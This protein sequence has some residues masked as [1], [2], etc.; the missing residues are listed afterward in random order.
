MLAV[1][2]SACL[3][4]LRRVEMAAGNSRYG[5]PN[6]RR[7]DAANSP[8]STRR[9]T[10]DLRSGGRLTATSEADVR[11]P[12]RAAYRARGLRDGITATSWPGSSMPV[13]NLKCAERLEWTRTFPGG[14]GVLE[15]EL[16]SSSRA[17]A[18]SVAISRP[19]RAVDVGGGPYV[20]GTRKHTAAEHRSQ[21]R[22]HLPILTA[23][24][25]DV[26]LYRS[27]TW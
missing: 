9:Q 15:V 13:G 21:H 23:R 20:S 6:R 14:G 16:A 2:V 26:G 12:R 8:A 17:P 10:R 3:E 24:R 27:T 5:G 4:Q 1:R 25:A 7:A 19:V 18:R 11:F 22:W